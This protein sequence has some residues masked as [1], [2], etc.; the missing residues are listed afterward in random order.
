MGRPILDQRSL[1]P[2]L[3]SLQRLLTQPLSS[4]AEVGYL[5]PFRHGAWLLPA[6]LLSA[7]VAKAA[8]VRNVL[9][10]MDGTKEYS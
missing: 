10:F 5:G 1:T 8:Q 6:L 4:D 2:H 3:S 7:L 9:G